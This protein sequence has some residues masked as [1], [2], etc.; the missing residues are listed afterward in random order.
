VAWCPECCSRWRL[1]DVA[2]IVIPP[3]A[4]CVSVT[5]TLSGERSSALATS[6]RIVTASASQKCSSLRPAQVELERLRLDAQRFPAVIRCSAASIGRRKARRETH[7]G[8]AHARAIRNRYSLSSLY[9]P[10]SVR[11]SAR[12]ST[13]AA[14]ISSS[15]SGP[16]T[17]AMP[18]G[19]TSARPNVSSSG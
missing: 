9:P 15:R 6:S 11:C 14:L 13:I 7:N 18:A 12:P 4:F 19:A 8:R 5:C 17:T 3:R 16:T 1:Y 10:S 2:V